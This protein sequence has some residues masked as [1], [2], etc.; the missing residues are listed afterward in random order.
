ML[1]RIRELSGTETI[2]SSIA[3]TATRVFY[4]KIAPHQ[5]TPSLYMREGLSG[6]EKVILD[7]ERFSGRHDPP[8]GSRGR[9]MRNT[10]CCSPMW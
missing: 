9:A 7:P 1:A 5:S 10:I 8:R 6:V 3:V 4:L 2:V